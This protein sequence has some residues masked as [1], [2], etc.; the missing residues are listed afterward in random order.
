MNDA[1]KPDAYEVSIHVTDEAPFY[2][3]PRRYSLHER[4][5]M[6][7]TIKD[8]MEKG[9][10][11]PS[12]SPYAS[13]VVM[14]KKKDDQYGMCI[15]YKVLNKKTIRVN[16]PM[17]LIEDCIDHLDG[18][19]IFSLLDLKSG[20]HQVRMAESSI[21]YAAFI[22]AEG[23]YEYTVMPFGLKNAPA[24]F[25]IYINT[26]F[27]DL[28]DK[29]LI[30]VYMDDIMIA[31]ADT[32]THFKIL[33]EVLKRLSDRGLKLNLDK[34]KFLYRKLDYLGYSVTADGLSMTD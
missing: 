27:R 31:T 8:L 6:R 17:P 12:T 29:Q 2:C 25:Q 9:M 21:K 33:T 28:L 13:P 16:F 7:S 15:D 20:F 4:S 24:E 19:K 11:R 30:T 10:V 26:I 34:S 3:N 14:A 32:E 23:Q 18:K 1:P 5:H 22:T